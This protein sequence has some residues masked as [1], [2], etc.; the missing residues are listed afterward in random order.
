MTRLASLGVALAVLAL[1]AQ[2]PWLGV[3]EGQ[4]NIIRRWLSCEECEQNERQYTD[5]LNSQATLILDQVLDPRSEGGQNLRGHLEASVRGQLALLPVDSTTDAAIRFFTN[6][7]LRRV[8]ERAA[9]ALGD[10]NAREGT[11]GA[12]TATINKILSD[13]TN[14]RGLDAA[15]FRALA[16][17]RARP[18]VRASSAVGTVTPGGAGVSVVPTARVSVLPA[19]VELEQ[20][21]TIV[22]SALAFDSLGSPDPSA[23]VSWRLAPRTGGGHAADL[24]GAGILAARR[25]GLDTVIAADAKGM[26]GR[27]AVRVT[28]IE[29]ITVLRIR[30]GDHQ[31]AVAGSE[32]P[33]P[34]VVEARVRG[35]GP[36]PNV[37]VAWGV[38]SGG[39]TLVNLDTVTDADG[40]AQAWWILGDSIGPQRARVSGPD[41]LVIAIRAR[42]APGTTIQGVIVNDRNGDGS[43]VDAE[44]ALPG[45]EVRLYK[46]GS[47]PFQVSPDSLVR[48]D[49]TDATGTFRFTDL[50]AGVYVVQP[51]SGPIPGWPVRVLRSDG[52]GD[53]ALVRT[54]EPEP[55]PGSGNPD[56]TLVPGFG[57][58]TVGITSGFGGALVLPR[59]DHDRGAMNLEAAMAAHRQPHFTFLFGDGTVQGRVLDGASALAGVTVRA[60]RC[61]TSSGTTSPPTVDTTSACVSAGAPMA[62]TTDAAGSFRFSGLLEGVWRVTVDPASI[63]RPGPNR[64]ALYLLRGRSARDSVAFD[65]R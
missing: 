29:P 47:P 55:P 40:R 58:R 1:P 33:S 18:V 4:R 49:T 52:G 54:A 9:I 14:A 25:P 61:A 28:R 11:R 36:A 46:G 15:V 56:A 43:V 21:D 6:N 32:L 22:F 57:G 19:Y 8:Q 16:A 7:E 37:R 23:V 35:V 42:G 63:G 59:W 39:G 3:S 64:H 60:V 12:A 30:G 24:V 45:A 48:T 44:E 13:S 38:E 27:A 53:T 65:L 62:T 5:S 41:G 10:M 2:C 20:G 26:E 50:P 34:V 51:V 17:A 31:S